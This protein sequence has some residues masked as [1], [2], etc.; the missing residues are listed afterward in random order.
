MDLWQEHYLAKPRM[1]FLQACKSEYKDN[2]P[3][4]VLSLQQKQVW[5]ANPA[6]LCCIVLPVPICTGLIEAGLHLQPLDAGYFHLHIMFCQNIMTEFL[7]KRAFLTPDQIISAVHSHSNGHLSGVGT[8]GS[9]S[10]PSQSH[11]QYC[12][13]WS[14]SPSTWICICVVP[15]A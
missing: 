1:P 8:K 2:L 12:Q 9:S 13:R 14:H 5:A 15:V 3:S 4:S 10:P 11:N 7:G 6:I